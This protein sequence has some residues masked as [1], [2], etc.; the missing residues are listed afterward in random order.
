MKIPLF[1]IE[2]Q[3]AIRFWTRRLAG[4]RRGAVAVVYAVLLLTMLGVL[5]AG[6]DL[7]N[8]LQ[9][10]YRLDL[11]ADAAALACGEAWQNSMEQGSTAANTP[12]LFAQLETTSN[13]LAQAQ[14]VNTFLAQAGQLGPILSTG[15]PTVSTTDS[16]STVTGGASVVCAV[17]YQAANPNFLMQ[18]VG[19]NSL[20]V[21]ETATSAVNLAPFAQ[22]YLILDTSASMMV[23]STPTDQG[24]IAAWV[25]ANDT[26]VAGGGGTGTA[27]CAVF[28]SC[29]G[30]P[31][32]TS[33]NLNHDITPC[34]F[35]CHDTSPFLVSDMQQGE[36]VAHLPSVNATTRFDVM[37]QAVVNDPTGQ[38]CGATG[39][40]ACD[41]GQTEGLLAYIRDTYLVTNTRASLSTFNYNMYGFNYGINGDEP[42]SAVFQQDVPDNS[43]LSIANEPSLA[44]VATKVNDLT[45]G[46]NTHLNPPVNSPHTAVLPALVTLVGTTQPGAGQTSANP[47][48]FVI[49]LT[50]GMNSDRNWNFNGSFPP[51]PIPSSI[52]KSPAID[53]TTYCTMWNA[54]PT[55]VQTI[56]GTPAWQGLS[57]SGA[58]NQ[59]N[60]SNYAPGFFNGAIP[61]VVGKGGSTPGVPPNGFK[62][63]GNNGVWYAG[64][65]QTS[66]CTTMKNSGV[67]IAVLETPYVPMTGQDPIFFPYEGT[68]QPVIWPQGN[69]VTHATSYPTGPNGTP[70]SALS[71]A[72]QSCA[73]SPNFYFQA[74]D[75]TTIATGFIQLFNSF[76]GQ[77]VHI[78]Q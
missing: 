55:T 38:F 36:T 40:V 27:A 26:G 74:S 48:K 59:C 37:K 50:D 75:D 3:S 52:V 65:I 70:M 4:D 71:Q 76:V 67:T 6:M 61:P 24:K 11:A 33:N 29:V 64:P 49:I 8:A 47:L 17:K 9:V 60:N 35:A 13:T 78:T 18:I 10:K 39:Q 42:S 43:Q 1:L 72:L 34:A 25:A 45:I 12:T 54:A 19:F 58:V 32:T 46:I 41:L 5:G 16:A 28:G 30:V 68:A 73:T 77:Y 7:S 14:G 57:G 63:V 23:G 53:T 51:D 21:S 22:V 15:F 69:P 56:G 66:F 62:L 44:N 2:M 31:L 20:T